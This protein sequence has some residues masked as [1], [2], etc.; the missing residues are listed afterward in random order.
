M[1]IDA[2][3]IYQLSLPLPIPYKVSQK[4]FFEFNP[5]FVEMHSD[6]GQEGWGEA[7]ITTGYTKETLD[8]G[9]E[10]CKFQAPTLL[11]L[12]TDSARTQIR[13]HASHS[14]VIT[15][16]FIAAADM[17]DRHPLLL[18]KESVSI[19]ILAPC[20]SR[21]LQAIR[22]EVD[23][24]IDDGYRTLKVKVGFD[25]ESDLKRVA[26][27]QEAAAGRASLRLD[28]N[29]AFSRAD[30]CAFASHLNPYGIE[31]LEQPCAADGWEDNA[32]VADVSNVPIMLDES[33][34][35]AKDIER[36]AKI[37]EVGYV[38]L[39]LKK[40]GGVEM[41]ANALHK[42]RKLGMEPVLGDG[43]SV[44]PACWAEA[45]VARSTITNAGE[46]NGFLK[47]KSRLFKNP[48]SFSKGCINLPQDY[49][50]KIDRN[51]VSKRKVRHEHFQLR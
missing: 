2:I 1:K 4:T 16:A 7:L 44:E 32:A 10:Y 12:D 50:P 33:I 41:L 29:R 5:I 37:R 20:Q 47:V 28:A 34:F 8:G 30:G 35:G 43:V 17:L 31:L 19:P 6:D 48:L 13:S 3:S 42:I 25:V 38:K 26:T 11:G 51:E 46:M 21:A 40:I 23:Q 39:K 22:D 18:I 14:P 24:L 49:W 27:I 15:S 9:W 36:A 45:C